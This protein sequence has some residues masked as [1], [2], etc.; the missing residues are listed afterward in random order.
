MRGSMVTLL[1]LAPSVLPA[2][3]A[4]RCLPILLDG[5]LYKSEQQFGGNVTRYFGGRVRFRCQ[6][7]NVQLEGDSLR[8]INDKIYIFSGRALYR[9]STISVSADTLTYLKE[10]PNRQQDET[11]LARGGVQVTDRKTGSTLQ[12][13]SV[14]FSRGA[15][16]GRG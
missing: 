3:S 6:R 2:Q 5:S 11:V 16:G 12:G 7:Q 4:K 1:L 9:D 10:A 14:D 15:K 13:P 8:I